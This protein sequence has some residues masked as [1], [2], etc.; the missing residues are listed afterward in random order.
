[1]RP[2]PLGEW[3][4]LQAR[5]TADADLTPLKSEV[6]A[7]FQQKLSQMIE[8]DLGEARAALESGAAAQAFDKCDAL[9]QLLAN[10]PPQSQVP[11]RHQAEQIVAQ[12]IDRHGLFIEPPRGTFLRGSESNYNTTMIPALIKAVRAKG[13]LPQPNSSAWADRWSQAP[14][15]LTLYLK[16]LLEGNYMASENRLTRI[17]AQLSLYHKGKEIWKTTPTARTAVPLPSLPAY[18]SSRLALSPARIEEFEHLLYVNARH[19]I[20]DK[21]A[22]FLSHIPPCGQQTVSGAL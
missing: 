11:L 3:L 22:F 13:Y 15:R 7:R 12:I 17:D 19:S 2:F 21:F 4:N 1:V 8:A 20:D 10:L 16:E 6:R 14:F 9:T 5:T 18:L